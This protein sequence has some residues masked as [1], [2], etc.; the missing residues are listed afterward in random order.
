MKNVN[1][2]NRKIIRRKIIF[3]LLD[4]L[5]IFGSFM[6]F[7]WF[8]PASKRIYLPTYF[9]PFLFFS[10]VWLS[11]SVIIAKYDIH[12]ARKPKHVIIPILITNLT[13]LAI[14]TTLIYSFGAF[15]YSRLIVFGTILLATVIEVILAYVYFSYKK[16]VLV[17]EFDESLVKKPRYY[18][19]DRSF[20]VEKEAEARYVETREQIK[21]I[22]INE[23]S[24]NVYDYVSRFVDVGN[25]D[26][27][28][29]STTT[30]FNIDQLPVNRFRS[31]VNLHKINDIR[32]INKFFESVNSRLPYGGVFID[33]AETYVLR[34]QRIL[35]K[36][37][38]V[39]NYI[40][41]F[42]DFV[43]TRVFPKLPVFKKIYFYITLGRNR[44]LSRAETLGRL[45]SCGFECIDE[46]FIDGMFYFVVRKVKE[47]LFDENPTY[48]PFVRLMR[49]GKN[50]KLIGVYKMRTMHAYSEYLQEYIYLKNN[51]QNGGKFKNDFRVTAAGHFM[52]K[53]W[54]D[55]LPMIFNIFRG[56]MKIVGVRPLSKHYFNL[57]TEELKQK[58]I[59]YKPGL[60]PP[61]Y[62]DMPN[63]LEEIMD[64]EIRYL[65]AYSKNPLWT[66]FRYFFMAFYN[67]VF[68]RARSK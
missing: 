12:K 7:I 1:S 28:V 56:D 35:K 27:L 54:L 25:P 32:R 26:N 57:Y 39:V 30:K 21:T 47:P 17:P 18:P 62:A 53:F 20:V 34:K 13:I 4:F 15:N 44:V 5:I 33:N 29:L 66:D 11:V 48:G 52:R 24:T 58:R 61:Y 46:K 8:K 45:Y 16:P 41:Y 68:R 50:G 40:Y 42:F 49:Y 23:S 19:A 38:P 22:I 3:I 51:L 63:T 64:S 55:E 67:I 36:Y 60:V 6:V 10:M 2:D 65:D 43:F 9:N 59:K 31:L 37:P 14:I